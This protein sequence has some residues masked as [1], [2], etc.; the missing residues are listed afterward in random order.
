M[1]ATEVLHPIEL[2]VLWSELQLGDLPFP[3]VIPPYGATIVER[4]RLREVARNR[5]R[6]RGQLDGTGV[7]WA[8]APLLRTLDRPASAVDILAVSPGAAPCTGVAATDGDAAVLAFATSSGMLALRRIRSA[9]LAD[10]V[11]GC[12]APAPAGPGVAAEIE[13][14]DRRTRGEP[15]LR[16]V[17]PD[18]PLGGGQLRVHHGGPDRRVTV[19]SWFDTC[20]GRYLAAPSGP[21]RLAVVPADQA[22]L[23]GRIAHLLAC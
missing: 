3:L 9:A 12:L 19:V 7:H 14:D 18:P 16:A 6:H 2:D 5:L 4:D 22:G 10:E 20:G 21:G 11:L 17:T 23:R 8:L 1:N 13:V 15:A